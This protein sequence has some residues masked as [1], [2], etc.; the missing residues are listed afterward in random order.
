MG[1]GSCSEY[2]LTLGLVP[3]NASISKKEMSRAKTLHR[4]RG[5]SALGG[6]GEGSHG[7]WESFSRKWI[8]IRS[9]GDYLVGSVASYPRGFNAC[10]G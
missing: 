8:S 4:V 6:L 9:N 5:R 3:C 2:G 1:W 7:S 10:I